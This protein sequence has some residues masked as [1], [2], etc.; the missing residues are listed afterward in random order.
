MYYLVLH[1]TGKESTKHESIGFAMWRSYTFRK[2]LARQVII[3]YLL[4]AYRYHLLAISL[5]GHR[6]FPSVIRV[7][8]DEIVLRLLWHGQCSC[9]RGTV[10]LSRLLFR[11]YLALFETKMYRVYCEVRTES[12][13]RHILFCAGIC[14]STLYENRTLDFRRAH[15]SLLLGSPPFPL[16]SRFFFLRAY[17]WCNHSGPSH[18]QVTSKFSSRPWGLNFVW[19][20]AGGVGVP[21]RSTWSQVFGFSWV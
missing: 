13:N 17:G 2:Q 6:E 16:L 7:L 18:L 4:I 19:R 15:H 5:V 1:E 8:M 10:V 14:P 3:V 9:M 21:W 11:K 20:W 12:L